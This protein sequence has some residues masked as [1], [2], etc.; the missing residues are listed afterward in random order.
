[1]RKEC[2]VLLAAGC[3]AANAANVNY[4]LLGRKGSKMNSPMVYKNVDYSKVKKTEQNKTVSSLESASLAKTGMPDGI[5]AVE[6]FYDSRYAPSPFYFRGVTTA[7][8]R[9]GG[10]LYN[11]TDYKYMWNSVFNTT[12]SQ[13]IEYSNTNSGYVPYNDPS[14]NRNQWTYTTGF[15][16]PTA[17]MNHMILP[18]PYDPTKTIAYRHYFA[19]VKNSFSKA[20]AVQNWYSGKA[21]DVGVYMAVDTKPA[22]VNPNKIP[23]YALYSASEWANQQPAAYPHEVRDSRALGLIADAS[24]HSVVSVGKALNP[25]RFV[26]QSPQIYIGV[27]ND[28]QG[29]SNGANY[30]SASAQALDNFIYN[31]RTAE[32]VPAGNHG[33]ATGYMAPQAHALNAITVGAIEADVYSSSVVRVP[34]Y[35]SS[36][37]RHNGSRKPEIYNFVHYVK[38]GDHARSYTKSNGSTEVF[39]PF[40]NGTEM[41]AAY[42]AGM[43]S[44]LLSVNPFYRW[45]PEV[46]KALLLTSSGKA[47]TQAPSNAVTTTA[48]SYEYW[49][50]DDG[51]TKMKFTYHS[52]YWNGDFDKLKTPSSPDAK[53]IWFV[54]PNNMGSKLNAAISWLNYGDDIANF[55]QVPQDFD[56]YVL[57]TYHPNLDVPG[58]TLAKS[59]S[60][61]DSFEKVSFNAG[62][63]P[64]LKFCIRLVN[65]N[66]ATARRGQIVLGFNLSN[67]V[68]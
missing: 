60:V 65:D 59:E 44:E 6:G 42:T 67:Q 53:E 62:D 1:M 66:S 19:N 15:D 3:V 68:Q 46:V 7:D 26:G 55:G 34:S 37:I 41:A 24:S 25:S 40:Y 50:F 5:G 27:R 13:L 17:N 30:Y 11:W 39:Q 35:S 21:S 10:A 18:S 54:M 9:F 12:N 4:D 28:R 43:V 29:G 49:V 58:D 36:V 8:A 20:N 23:K 33:D 57:G 52:R 32:F 47:I 64:F 51:G 22:K 61:Y 56:L 63:Y 38:S 14:S 2:L 45:H 31:N 48:P 16:H